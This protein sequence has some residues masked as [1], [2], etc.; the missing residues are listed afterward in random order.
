MIFFSG[1]VL[2]NAV[3]DAARLI[4]TGQAQSGNFSKAKFKSSVCD[5]LAMFD[6]AKL[7]INVE[8]FANFG[9]VALSDPLD[10]NGNL[11]NGF[12]Y[13]IGVGGDVVLVRVF[14]EWPL[15]A[16]GLTL[17]KNMGTGNRLLT[18]VQVFRNEPF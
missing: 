4:R 6:C 11:K 13:N 12:P 17:M 7:V 8:T 1:S 16:P 2:E 14:Y 18:A 9:N 10:N 15:I 3:A 5:K